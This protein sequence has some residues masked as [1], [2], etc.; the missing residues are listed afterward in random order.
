[1]QP[2]KTLERHVILK[3][4][5][6]LTV[7]SHTVELPDGRVIKDWPW[8][9]MPDFV[10]VLALTTDQHLICF[11]QTKYSVDGESLAPVGG[12]VEPG[13]APEAAARRE[14]LEETGYEAPEWIKLGSFPI[15]GNRGAGMAHF[16]IAKAAHP[17]API[18][19]DDL[20]E[21]HMVFLT[22]DEIK[23][24]LKQGQFKLL[25]WM[26]IIS[27]GLQILQEQ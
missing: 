22:L 1:M 23:T 21:Q 16:F 12:Y 25:P 24:A 4:N 3:H 2:W 19:A 26:A 20:E 8:L 9:V 11:R 10:N 17:V 6:F 15:D 5:K 13:E 14:L 18:T 27:L 7:E